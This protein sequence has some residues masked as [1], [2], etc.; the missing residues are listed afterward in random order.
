MNSARVPVGMKKHF[1][2]VLSVWSGKPALHIKITETIDEMG[3]VIDSSQ[4]SGTTIYGI[5]SPASYDEKYYAPG[6]IQSGDLTAFFWYT[7]T[8]TDV[9]A[10]KQITPTTTRHDHIIYQGVEYTVMLGEI[11]YDV[12]TSSVDWEPVFARYKL[13]KIAP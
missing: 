8:D 5:I 3:N 1:R 9:L 7:G 10:S 2:Q 6:T 13:T 12:L 11:A 4:D